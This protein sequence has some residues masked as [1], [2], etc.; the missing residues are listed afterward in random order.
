MATD[1][2]IYKKLYVYNDD[3]EK[4]EKFMSSVYMTL[5]ET[6]K[7]NGNITI[8]SSRCKPPSWDKHKSIGVQSLDDIYIDKNIKTN[9]INHIDNFISMK[10]KYVKFGRNHKLNM[11]F[12]GI[13]GSGKTCL[14][15]ALAKKYD[16]NVYILNFSKSLTDETLIDLINDIKD[17][18]IIIFEDIDSHFKGRQSHNTNVSYSCLLNILDG[19]IS[20]SGSCIIT[21]LTANNPERLEP[22]LIRPGRIDKIVVF[23]YPKREEVYD[24]FKSLVENVDE[25][26]FQTFYDKIKTIKFN[27]SGLVDYLFRHFDN[28]LENLDEFIEHNKIMNELINDQSMKIYS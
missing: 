13:P 9:L 21:I 3:L 15:K 4:I 7:E 20:K 2:V 28:Y 11:L 8:Y 18:S 1:P 27:M 5:D 10:D 17:N 12:A 23:D 26:E 25:N 6:K 19:F 22:S 24:C 14:C 16:F